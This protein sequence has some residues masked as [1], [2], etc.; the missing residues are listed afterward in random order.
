MLQSRLQVLPT[1]KGENIMNEADNKVVERIITVW[2]YAI[3][4][5]IIIIVAVLLAG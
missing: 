5:V 2:S 3:V 1:N 4:T